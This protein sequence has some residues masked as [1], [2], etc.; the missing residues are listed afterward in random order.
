MS[1]LLSTLREQRDERVQEL[2]LDLPI[3][4]WDKS[5]VARFGV[6]ERKEIEAIGRRKRNAETDMDF[7]IRA[8]QEIYAY[9][10]GKTAEGKRMEHN[11]SYVRVEDE[12]GLPILFDTR[13][14]EKMGVEDATTARDV[15]RYLVK[16]NDIALGGMGQRVITWMQNTDADVADELVGE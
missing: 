11:E 8:V 1:D 13:L 5:L 10:P 14:A 15:L 9:D 12:Q 6:M 7:L 16:F 3:P 4:T 2:Y